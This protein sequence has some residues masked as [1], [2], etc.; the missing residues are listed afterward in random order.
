MDYEMLYLMEN[1]GIR[2]IENETVLEPDKKY[3]GV[4][5]Y[6]EAGTLGNRFGLHAGLLKRTLSND[7]IRFESYDRL[8]MALYCGSRSGGNEARC[9]DDASFYPGKSLF[10]CL[11]GYGIC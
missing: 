4:Y 7:S 8:D 1:A 5:T 2:R 10:Y 9:P 3:I 11:R 6:E